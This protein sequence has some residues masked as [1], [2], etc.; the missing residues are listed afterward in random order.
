MKYRY[1]IY[2]FFRVLRAVRWFC[3]AGSVGLVLVFCATVGLRGFFVP[4]QAHYVANIN[5]E[6]GNVIPFG[7]D[8]LPQKTGEIFED[9]HLRFSE[10]IDKIYVTEGDWVEKGKALYRLDSKKIDAV[11]AQKK[12]Q[13]FILQVKRTCLSHKK[14][15]DTIA[16]KYQDQRHD[17]IY[18]K[19]AYIIKSTKKICNRHYDT[20]ATDALFNKIKKLNKSQ[21]FVLALWD[22]LESSEENSSKQGKKIA[23]FE[24]TKRKNMLKL[25]HVYIDR[26]LSDAYEALYTHEVQALSLE[27]R[28]DKDEMLREIKILKKDINILNILRKKHIYHAEQPGYIFTLRF[29]GQSDLYEKNRQI[30]GLSNGIKTFDVDIAVSPRHLQGL[31]KNSIVGISNDNFK[32]YVN[33]RIASV[34]NVKPIANDKRGY[35]SAKLVFVPQ[36]ID[37]LSDA[38][39]QQKHVS[40]AWT[41]D[42]ELFSDA[43][44][45]VWKSGVF[46]AQ[47][48]TFQ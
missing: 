25:T 21:S 30:L 9:S 7:R 36:D 47:A 4:V 43:L 13:L 19:T 35:V 23:K 3:I 18:G 31:Q 6:K 28:L 39:Q 5:V 17:I 1:K 34:E 22:E 48:Q 14:T 29:D 24:H 15:I 27:K 12:R 45:R 42:E 32:S 33:A 38:S 41:L 8:I 40:V 46:V 44:W 2:S 11:L 37:F 26:S 16:Q 10:F 20:P